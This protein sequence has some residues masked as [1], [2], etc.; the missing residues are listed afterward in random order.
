MFRG[1][2]NKVNSIFLSIILPLSWALMDKRCSIIFQTPLR[3]SWV[4]ESLNFLISFFLVFILKNFLKLWIH[5]SFD[6][7]IRVV[8]SSLCSL[9]N[10]FLL[11]LVLPGMLIKNQ[12]G[13]YSWMLIVCTIWVLFPWSFSSST[14]WVD[15]NP[16]LHIII[17]QYKTRKTQYD[18]KARDIIASTLTLD[19]FYRISI[20]KITKEM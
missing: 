18:A 20:C 17:K 2:I 5:L 8:Y 15:Q 3:N 19:E 12:I 10:P 13:F 9:L 16:H 1:L 7:W 14:F 11:V 4:C 6:S